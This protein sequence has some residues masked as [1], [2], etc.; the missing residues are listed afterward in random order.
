MKKTK[1][2]QCGADSLGKMYCCNQCKISWHN[3]N[4]ILKPNVVG[5]CVICGA[6][7]SRW[8]SPARQ[9]RE[10]DKRV[11]CGR[12]CAGKGRMGKRHPQWR[13]GRTID[14][15]GYVLVYKP[16]HPFSDYKGRVREHRIVMEKMIGRILLQSEVVHHL[17]DNPSNNKPS[18]LVLYASNAEHKA[19]DNKRRKRDG[20]GRLIKRRR[21]LQD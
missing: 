19:E 8:E 20:N 17:D 7:V 12:T 6:N 21:K 5:K 10:K 16:D 18:N 9:K 13:G 15:Y 14:K 11:F 1:C 4:R 3:A 2:R